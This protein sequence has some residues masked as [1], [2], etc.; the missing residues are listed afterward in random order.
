[1]GDIGA[2][3]GVFETIAVGAIMTNA[4]LTGFV[5]S[6]VMHLLDSNADGLSQ[7][8]RQHDYRVWAV[9][10]FSEHI[11]LLFRNFMKNLFNRPPKWIGKA[12]MMAAQMEKHTTVRATH[13]MGG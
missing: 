10:I 2:W 7:Q 3:E 4:A 13:T 8:E 6:Q 5:G 11:L 1:M 12:R 9:V